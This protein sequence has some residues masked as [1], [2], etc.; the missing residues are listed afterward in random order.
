MDTLFVMRRSIKPVALKPR[1]G[2]RKKTPYPEIIEHPPHINQSAQLTHCSAL[3]KISFVQLYDDLCAHNRETRKERR[4][5]KS[6][7]CNY[8]ETRDTATSFGVKGKVFSESAESVLKGYL[9]Y[10]RFNQN[11]NERL[12][13]KRRPQTQVV[14]ELGYDDATSKNCL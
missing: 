12:Y 1:R 4:R 7:N 9:I 13:D 14:L 6:A 3:P 10:A 5:A 2:R 8:V 11:Q